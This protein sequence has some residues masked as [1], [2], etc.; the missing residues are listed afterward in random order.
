MES[1]AGGEW[2][3][4]LGLEIEQQCVSRDALD[5]RYWR[6]AEPVRSNPLMT[7][8]SEKTRPR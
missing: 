1:Q 7:N 4:L 5:S 6:N 2:K 8:G 3:V